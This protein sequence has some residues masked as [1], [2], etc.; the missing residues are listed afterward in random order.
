MQVFKPDTIKGTTEYGGIVKIMVTRN[1][2]SQI[3]SGVFSLEKGEGLVKDIHEKNEVFYVIEGS[4]TV[5]SPDCDTVVAK[6]GKMIY[7]PKRTIHFSKKLKENTVKV[8]W[9]NIEP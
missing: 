6:A 1:M 2:G 5:E 8:F 4:L 7:I 9:C 3:H